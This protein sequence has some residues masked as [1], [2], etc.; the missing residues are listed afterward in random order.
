MIRSSMIYVLMVRKIKKS[1]VTNQTCMAVTTFLWVLCEDYN[2]E[3]VTYLKS[4]LRGSS[5]IIVYE[6][7][8]IENT[9]E[10]LGVV[11]SMLTQY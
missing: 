7:K 3:F 4:V 10:Y 9:P 8:Q 5:I 1:N 6:L 2:V 11:N